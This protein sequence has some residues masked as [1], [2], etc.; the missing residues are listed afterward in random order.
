MGQN[1]VMR[2]IVGVDGSEPAQRAVAWCATYAGKLDAEV[3]ALYALDFPVTTES[4]FGFAPIPV[5][6]PAPTAAERAHLHEV[7]ERDWCAALTTAGVKFRVVVAEG[8]AASAIIA[9]ADH[10]RADLV[11]TGRRG[12]GGFAELL[13]GS[14]SHHLSHHLDRPLVIV[15]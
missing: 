10:E 5:P 6:I 9:A 13:L 14:T 4:G 7:I 3:V 8:E 11:V 1:V 15:P 2:I 12:R